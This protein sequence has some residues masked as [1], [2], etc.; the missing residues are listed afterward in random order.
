MLRFNIIAI[1]LVK[2]CKIRK[3]I[4]NHGYIVVFYQFGTQ[5]GLLSS[6]FPGKL[7]N[8]CSY[9]SD[10]N[11]LSLYNIVFT[12]PL[13]QFLYY[14]P[15]NQAA[16]LLHTFYASRATFYILLMIGQYMLLRRTFTSI[17]ST[18]FVTSK[19]D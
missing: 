1:Q 19:T 6:N 11:Q 9:A 4:K 16:I 13:I 7:L 2:F 8:L 10:E 12:Y 17:L 15:V 3:L 18:M 14:V 5:I